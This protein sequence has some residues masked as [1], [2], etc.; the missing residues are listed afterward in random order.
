MMNTRR[1]II[2][3]NSSSPPPLPSWPV[4]SYRHRPSRERHTKSQDGQ[5]EQTCGQ[6]SHG[7]ETITLASINVEVSRGAPS[8]A[9]GDAGGMGQLLATRFAATGL[10]AMRLVVFGPKIDT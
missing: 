9:I 8:K 3:G 7:T 1:P 6:G 5:Q 10:S 2:P 4:Q